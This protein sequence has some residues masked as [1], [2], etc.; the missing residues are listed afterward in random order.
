M[1]AGLSAWI[2]LVGCFAVSFSQPSWL[3]FGQLVSGWILCPG[4]RTVTG[5]LRVLGSEASGAHDAYHR[6]LREGA[7]SME[8]LWRTMARLLVQVHVGRSGVVRLALDDTLF[9]RGGPQVE[10]AGLYRDA[11]RSFGKRVVLARG[12][13]VLAVTL[14]VRPPWGG[15]PLGLPIASRLYRKCGPTRLVLAKQMIEEIADMLPGYRFELVC[16]G[17]YAGLAGDELPRTTVISRMRRDAAL[18]ELAPQRRRG[19]PGRPRT[20]GARLPV[21]EQLARRARTG[22]VERELEMRGKK[23]SRLL[24]CKTVLWY[25]V[26]RQPVLLVIVRD[27]AGVEHDDFFF[28]TDIGMAPES[29]AE[30]YADRWAVEDAFR[31]TKQSL[32]GQQPQ[33]WIDEGP[34]RASALSLWLYAAVWS[35]YVRVHGAKAT[36]K[37]DPWY[38]DK[39]TP[40]FADALAALRREL[41]EDRVFHRS[42]SRAHTAKTLTA[43]LETLARAA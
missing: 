26:S 38:T 12:L 42:A 29:V 11:V 41:W 10:G 34:E 35:W 30:Q 21:P 17:A 37:T 23:K 43:L 14:Q 1:S 25:K 22:W 8:W 15:E 27:P 9:H 20:K 3:L 19:R 39:S 13:N 24:W 16:D 32:G 7:W 4:R 18:F 36:W 2:D 6:L 31:A 28:T 40:S 5:M 33:T